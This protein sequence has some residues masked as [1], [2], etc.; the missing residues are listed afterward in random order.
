MEL[1]DV[2]LESVQHMFELY[3]TALDNMYR[4]LMSDITTI[5]I[6]DDVD[7]G[8]KWLYIGDKG[9]NGSWRIGI[10]GTDLNSERRESG[11]WVPKAASTP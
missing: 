9:T 11:T 6:T 10:S 3:K 4:Y 8:G 5:E 1:E 7:S 2:T